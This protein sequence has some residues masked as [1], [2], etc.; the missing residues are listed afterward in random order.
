MVIVVCDRSKERE[1]EI[2]AKVRLQVTNN[3]HPVSGP[4]ALVK[5]LEDMR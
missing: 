5:T 3:V 4:E 2:I 1:S